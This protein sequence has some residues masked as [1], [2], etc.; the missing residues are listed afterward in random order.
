LGFIPSAIAAWYFHNNYL[1]WLSIILFMF[2]KMVTMLV[3]LP[4]SLSSDTE[5]NAVFLT[6]IKNEI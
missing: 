4:K 6:T 5:V 3:Y 1:L 2:A